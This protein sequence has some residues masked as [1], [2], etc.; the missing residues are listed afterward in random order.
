MLHGRSWKSSIGFFPI[1][2]TAGEVHGWGGD[3]IRFDLF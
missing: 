3:G 1:L 2:T